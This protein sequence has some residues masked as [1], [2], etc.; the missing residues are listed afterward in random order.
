[1]CDKLTIREK[2]KKKKINFGQK[3]TDETSFSN[4]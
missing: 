3:K 4:K 2:M 1:M